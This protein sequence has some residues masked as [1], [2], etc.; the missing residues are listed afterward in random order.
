M[1]PKLQSG[2]C[3]RPPAN[4][5]AWMGARREVVRLD[6][7]S[8]LGAHGFSAGPANPARTSRRERGTGRA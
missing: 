1:T 6:W 5:G 7:R 8:I 3:Y 2:N 4:F